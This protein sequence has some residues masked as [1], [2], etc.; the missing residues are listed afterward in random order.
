MFKIICNIE[1]LANQQMNSTTG[2]R[3]SSVAMIRY[4][5]CKSCNLSSIK[6]TEDS[7]RSSAATVNEVIQF[8]NKNGL[9]PYNSAYSEAYKKILASDDLLQYKY[10]AL[11]E[12][13]ENIN[14]YYSNIIEAKVSFLHEIIVSTESG[15]IWGKRGFTMFKNKPI[16]KAGILEEVASQGS[17]EQSTYV[18]DNYFLKYII[19]NNYLECNSYKEVGLVFPFIDY[20]G[21]SSLFKDD[22]RQEVE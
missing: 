11:V 1:S 17:V 4:T 18:I 5:D 14:S 3:G 20:A 6:L 10:I 7:A 2:Y 12:E 9:S 19:G 21:L 8:S 16:Y 15:K 22:S 13:S